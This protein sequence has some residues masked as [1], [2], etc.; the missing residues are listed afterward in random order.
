MDR[1]IFRS[2]TLN[3]EFRTEMHE[4]VAAEI[5]SLHGFADV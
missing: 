2:F 5:K 3:S 1:S 4:E